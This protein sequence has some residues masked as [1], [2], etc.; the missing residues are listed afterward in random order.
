[1]KPLGDVIHR[2]EPL[3]VQFAGIGVFRV[4]PWVHEV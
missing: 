3:G 2:I 1:M 4:E